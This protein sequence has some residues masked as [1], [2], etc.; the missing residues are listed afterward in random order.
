M[1][2]K[3]ERDRVD[4]LSDKTTR[5]KAETIIAS[6]RPEFALLHLLKHKIPT[7]ANPSDLTEAFI[8]VEGFATMP[9]PAMDSQ[10]R[11]VQFVSQ[12]SSSSANRPPPVSTT[13]STP[14]H[15]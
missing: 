10:Q 4:A 3:Q 7:E 11:C 8:R 9:E 1:C 12:I 2:L 14:S 5:L 15:K 13:A 6:L